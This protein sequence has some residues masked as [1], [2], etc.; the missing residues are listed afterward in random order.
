MAMVIS[1]IRRR[2]LGRQ[3]QARDMKPHGR[4]VGWEWS[5]ARGPEMRW[6]SPSP[7]PRSAGR[8]DEIGVRGVAFIRGGTVCQAPPGLRSGRA[9]MRRGRALVPPTLPPPPNPLPPRSG[10][11]REEGQG[12]VPH[13]TPRRREEPKAAATPRRAAKVRSPSGDGTAR[14]RTGAR[15]GRPARSMRCP[16]AEVGP[17]RSPERATAEPCP[18]SPERVRREPAQGWTRAV[19][20]PHRA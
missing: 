3:R 5:R 8:G 4:E 11:K 12:E 7:S 6:P 20:A 1:R 13:F 17:I 18:R 15:S 14:V 10:A 16:R 2:E 19:D 9:G